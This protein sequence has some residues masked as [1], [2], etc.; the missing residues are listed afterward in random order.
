MSLG[1]SATLN[2]TGSKNV[3]VG[4]N[5]LDANTTA[6]DNTAVGYASLSATTGV[7]TLLLATNHLVETTGESNSRWRPL[8]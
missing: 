7:T 3:T 1:R 2:T 5:A 4:R 8:R 6:G